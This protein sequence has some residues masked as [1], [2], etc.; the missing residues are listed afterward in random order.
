MYRNSHGDEGRIKFYVKLSLVKLESSATAANNLNFIA[1][2]SIVLHVFVHITHFSTS[3]RDPGAFLNVKFTNGKTRTRDWFHVFFFINVRKTPPAFITVIKSRG[4][5]G[6]WFS[7]EHF[8]IVF[9]V[10]ANDN[11]QFL[12][13]LF[14][15]FVYFT[16][17]VSIGVHA[18]HRSLFAGHSAINA[19]TECNKITLE[20]CEIGTFYFC[21]K[22]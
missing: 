8:A 17:H 5:P 15:L 13:L 16:F 4:N 14:L 10:S 21:E 20:N 12:I 3:S 9:V 19:K 6:K 2:R 18:A 1:C 22:N 7:S 11:R